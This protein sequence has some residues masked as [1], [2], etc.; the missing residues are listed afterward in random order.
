LMLTLKVVKS[1]G[2]KFDGQQMSALG[3]PFSKTPPTSGLF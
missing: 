3:P 1:T 2:V